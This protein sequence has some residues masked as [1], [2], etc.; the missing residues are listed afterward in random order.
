MEPG[1]DNQ[2]TLTLKEKALGIVLMV[3]ETVQF[4]LQGVAIKAVLL[5]YH[6]SSPEVIYYMSIVGLIYF[7][8]ASRHA[9]QD[10]YGNI[11]KDM[12][13]WLFARVFFGCVQDIFVYVAFMFTSYSK[14]NCIFYCNCLLLPPFAWYL[15][16]EPISKW[17][18]LGIL[19][20]FSGMLLIIQPWRFADTEGGVAGDQLHDLI[21]IVLALL[22]AITGALGFIGVRKVSC[23]FHY[24]IGAFFW[25]LGNLMITPLQALFYKSTQV[26]EYTP[27]FLLVLVALGASSIVSQTLCNISFKYVTASMTGVIVYLAIPV[28]YIL[29]IIFL[30]EEVGSLEIVGACLIVFINVF[31][32]VL[33]VKGVIQ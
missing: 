1:T 26:P 8:S 10:I 3:I 12:R 6:A 24:T 9:G 27:E 15:L 5:K 29:D 16:N 19:V 21:G 4:S 31:L 32:G 13:W 7:Y 11:P 28:G 20:G 33:K 2:G 23:N 14:A 25:N 18:V 30:G 22:S 17:D